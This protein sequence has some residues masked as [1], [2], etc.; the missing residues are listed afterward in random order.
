MLKVTHVIHDCHIEMQQQENKRTQKAD[1]TECVCRAEWYFD[2]FSAKIYSF[3]LPFF[4]CFVRKT[5][6]CRNKLYSI[7]EPVYGRLMS[8]V[9]GSISFQPNCIVIEMLSKCWARAVSTIIFR[10]YFLMLLLPCYVSHI[11]IITEHLFILSEMSHTHTLC[12]SPK[13]GSCIQI[14]KDQ[15]IEIFCFIYSNIFLFNSNIQLTQSMAL[16]DSFS[17]CVS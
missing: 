17:K 11:Q 3:F 1:A 7:Y 15:L 2:L 9:L 5:T 16:F 8:F 12:I 4:F 6:T 14:R 10:R 13:T